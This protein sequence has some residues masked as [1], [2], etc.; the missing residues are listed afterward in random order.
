MGLQVANGASQMQCNNAR[1]LNQWF[2]TRDE[3]LC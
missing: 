1:I 3:Q 2:M